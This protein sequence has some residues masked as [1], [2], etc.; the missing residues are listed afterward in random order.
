MEFVQHGA[1]STSHITN[2]NDMM[3]KAAA[4]C[5]QVAMQTLTAG[6]GVAS[7]RHRPSVAMLLPEAK[8]QGKVTV[9]TCI[10]LMCGG[11]WHS[12]M[13][14]T[15]DQ[16]RCLTGVPPVSL[17][18]LAHHH[19]SVLCQVSRAIAA[20][21]AAKQPIEH[22]KRAKAK[23]AAKEAR[24]QRKKDKQKLAKQLQPLEPKCGSDAS[25]LVQT[26]LKIVLQVSP[27]FSLDRVN[28]TPC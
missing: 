7:L 27:N 11:M 5:L 20:D 13:Q 1:Q 12:W 14:Y 8:A 25:A 17:S 19:L 3:G 21:M 24:K 6:Q 23:T 10:L 2:I 9:H 26:Q 15:A 22:E 16:L 4:T 28:C 18:G